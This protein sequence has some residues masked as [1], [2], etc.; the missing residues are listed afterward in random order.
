MLTSADITASL[1]QD[2]PLTVQRIWSKRKD[3]IVL[4]FN[5]TNV[6][7]QSLEF[8]GVGIPM[9]YNNDWINKGQEVT[10]T[11]SVA[12]DPAV[13]LD[14]GYVITNRLTGNPPTLVTAPTEKSKLECLSW[15][16]QALTCDSPP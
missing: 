12:S 13:S 7:T 2:L 15:W 4:S 16:V 14:G 10:W 3:S 1:G 6:G 5:I 9:P 8:G 11:E